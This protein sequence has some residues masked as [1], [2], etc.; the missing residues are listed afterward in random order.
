MGSSSGDD[1]DD[2]PKSHPERRV[3]ATLTYYLGIEP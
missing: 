1:E 3:L 2:E